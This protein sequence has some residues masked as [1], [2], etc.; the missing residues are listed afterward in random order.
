[1][2]IT[3][4]PIFMDAGSLNLTQIVLS[5]V[6][7]FNFFIYFPSFILCF[8]A[9]LAE[10]IEYLLIYQKQNQNLYQDIMLNIHL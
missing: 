2:L 4:L 7:C 1:M 8:I 6:G 3:L 5:Q 9:V 10:T